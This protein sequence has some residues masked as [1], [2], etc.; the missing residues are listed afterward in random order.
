MF[1]STAQN[2][3]NF[4]PIKVKTFESLIKVIC[5]DD[6]KAYSLSTYHDEYRNKKNF[7]STRCIGL[8][9]D[10]DKNGEVLSLEQAKE[11]FKEYKHIIATTR[12]HQIEKNGIVADRFRVILFFEQDIVDSKSFTLAWHSLKKLFPVIDPA[13]KDESRYWFPSKEII[14]FQKAGKFVDI[15]EEIDEI[16]ADEPKELDIDLEHTGKLSY[17]TMKFLCQGADAGERNSKL[18]KVAIDC[19]EQGYDIEYVKM[20]VER[21]IQITGNWGSEHLN[22]KDVEAIENAYKGDIKYDKREDDSDTTIKYKFVHIKDT[23]ADDSIKTEWLIDGF[24]SKGGLSLFAGQPKSGKS[25]ITRQSAICVAQG[26]DFL[27]RKVTQGVV[28]YLAMEDQTSQVKDQFIA[29]KVNLN[30][31]IY[32]HYGPVEPDFGALKNLLVTNGVTYLIID[33]LALFLNPDDLNNYNNIN[34]ILKDL[35]QVARDTGCH[36]TLIHHQ[37]KSREGG[38]LSIMGSNAIHGAVDNAIVLETVGKHRYISSSQRGGVRFS[39]TK[40]SFNNDTQIYKVSK[41]QTDKYDDSD[42]F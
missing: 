32:V 23:V 2:N 40:L 33:T 21:M 27:N 28:Y 17:N 29:Q 39:D 3:V 1:I 13:C 19:R 9:I 34:T 7:K 6:I 14:Q 10:N 30:D 20:M 35:R 5:G 11:T 41:K 36:I 38:T 25:T 16:L 4:K 37:N 42:D 18:F 22:A 31:S 15:P 26:K 24:L 8:D 12:S